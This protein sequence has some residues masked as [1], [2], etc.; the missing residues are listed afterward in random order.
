MRLLD[1]QN[2]PED[3]RLVINEWVSDETEERI[4]DLIPSG[5]ITSLTRLVL[6]NAVYFNAEWLHSFDENSTQDSPFH[7]LDGDD[8][9]VPMM[10]SQTE[11]FGYVAGEGYQAVELP[12]DGGELSMVVLRPALGNFVSFESALDTAQVNTILSEIRSENIQLS[13]PK[14]TFE[15]SVGLKDKL[16]AMGMSDA[17]CDCRA[18]FSGMDGTWDFFISD[19]LHKAFVS[20]DEAGTEAVASTAVIVGT[21]GVLPPPIVASFHPETLTC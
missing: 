21:T 1:F 20:V 11:S 4:R 5:A 7:L 16:I 6:T 2:A 17:F 12:Y 13:M 19:V 8:V 18:D 3:A 15:S 10:M 9:A 14:F